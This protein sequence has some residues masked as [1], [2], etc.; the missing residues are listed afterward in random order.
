MFCT[1]SLSV[2]ANV[3]SN[4]SRAWTDRSTAYHLA[5]T[6]RSDQRAVAGRLFVATP[7]MA[8]AYAGVGF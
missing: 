1:N 7:R 3:Q 6:A 4:L 5:G 2:V 8:R